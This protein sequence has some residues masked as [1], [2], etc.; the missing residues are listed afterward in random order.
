MFFRC[1]VFVGC[2][3]QKFL[4]II[5]EYLSEKIWKMKMLKQIVDNYC[6]SLRSIPVTKYWKLQNISRIWFRNLKICR[7]SENLR[8]N[9]RSENRDPKS[10][11]ESQKSWNKIVCFFN[12]KNCGKSQKCWTKNLQHFLQKVSKISFRHIEGN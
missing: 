11:P 9:P 7:K 3:S 12:L 2:P 1:C 6:G 4:T 10:K 8:G 5:M